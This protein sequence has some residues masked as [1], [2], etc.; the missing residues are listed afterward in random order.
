MTRPPDFEKI[1]RGGCR[2]LVTGPR[3]W[4]DTT[5][6]RDGLAKVWHPT[7]TLVHGACRTGADTLAEACWRH[8]GGRH[9]ERHPAPS[10]YVPCRPDCN[11]KQRFDR[12]GR[13]YCPAPPQRRNR[14]M[15]ARGADV[16]LAFIRARSTGSLGCLLA[17]LHAGIPSLIYH[18]GIGADLLDRLENTS[19][20][21]LIPA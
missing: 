19:N 8:W 13:R 14:Q 21:T 16:C 2:V 5:L 7:N 17:A 12:N 1:R 6:I 10:V 15:V 11:H 9:I 20:A 18:S 3:D 4:N